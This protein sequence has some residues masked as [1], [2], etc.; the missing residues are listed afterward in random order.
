MRAVI[1]FELPKWLR[2]TIA[3]GYNHLQSNSPQ[4]PKSVPV[5]KGDKGYDNSP[6]SLRM[7]A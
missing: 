6:I 4:Y 3:K 5:D 1:R 7:L 2:Q